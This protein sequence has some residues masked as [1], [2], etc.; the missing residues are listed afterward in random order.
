MKETFQ[1]YVDTDRDEA[2][3]Q[4]YSLFSGF[5]FYSA[6]SGWGREYVLCKCCKDKICMLALLYV[7]NK[8]P[9]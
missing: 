3:D 7:K 6:V 4:C 1:E 8:P 2:L 5:I 9:D